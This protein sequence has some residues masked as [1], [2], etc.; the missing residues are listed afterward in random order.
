[1][2]R[3]QKISNIQWVT[4][5]IK[6]R[7]FRDWAASQLRLYQSTVPKKV[8][9]YCLTRCDCREETGAGAQGSDEKNQSRTEGEQVRGRV[10]G[11][12]AKKGGEERKKKDNPESEH[13]D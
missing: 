3:I 12:E 10:W 13:T 7:Q 6:T 9:R 4:I 2:H 1:M 5:S 11:C 8:H